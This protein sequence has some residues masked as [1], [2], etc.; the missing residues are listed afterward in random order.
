LLPI[1][2]SL[3]F[4]PFY[5]AGK[6]ESRLD[7][8]PRH[9]VSTTISEDALYHEMHLDAAGLSKQAFYYACKGYYKLA[10]KNKLHNKGILAICDFTQSSNRKRFYVLDMQDKSILL[11]TY[12]A[13]GRNSGAEYARRFSN[14]A[15]S[16]ES[17]LGF[18]I[19]GN[20]YNGEHGPSLKMMGLEKGF[21]DQA[22]RRNIVIHGADYIG[23]D[24]QGNYKGRSYGCPAV[25][26][27]E[28][29]E[30]INMLKEGACLFIFYPTKTYLKRSKILNG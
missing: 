3:L 25:P 7:K 16:N 20:I 15:R 12:V 19:T 18:Y 11:N 2:A 10:G 28:C 23:E 14:R 30:I 1:S 8:S 24:W 5:P 26:Q 22:A 4:A 13:H 17:S 27:E 21:N 6:V 29:D 9:T